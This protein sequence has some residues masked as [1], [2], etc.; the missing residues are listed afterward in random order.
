MKI[1]ELLHELSSK[2]IDVR[3]HPVI[4]INMEALNRMREVVLDELPQNKLTE[5]MDESLQELMPRET[6]VN[7]DIWKE[8][9]ILK[10]Q[11]EKYYLHL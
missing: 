4:G 8:C 1:E 5:K 6:Y 2:L 10:I 9:V 11:M 7:V 3:Y